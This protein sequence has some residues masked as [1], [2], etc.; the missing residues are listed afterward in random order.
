MLKKYIP[1][2]LGIVI[3]FGLFIISINNYLLF[4]SIAEVF[5]IIVAYGIF[6][7]S[8]NCRQN[9]ENKY[10]LLLGIAYFFVGC[11][12]FLHTLAYKGM[13]VFATDESNLPT[14]LWITAR[15]LE[16]ISLFIAPFFLKRKLNISYVFLCYC[17]L[18][19]IVL[20][21]I[22]Y[23]H[24]F[25]DSFIEGT[26]LTLFKKL[27]ELVI[28]LIFCGA[29]LQLSRNRQRFDSQVLRILIASILI[30]ICAEVAFIFYVD[31]YGLSNFFGHI[32]KIISF[33]LIYNAL[34]KTALIRPFDLLYRDLKISENTLRESEKRL[35]ELN[36]TKDRFFSIIAH[37]LRSPLVSMISVIRYLIDEY[38]SISDSERMKFIKEIDLISN[39]TINLLDNLLDWAKCQTGDM[40]FQPDKYRV[41]DLL[42][43]ATI[44][45]ESYARNKNIVFRIEAENNLCVFVDR[46]MIITVVRNLVSNAIKFSYPNSDIL[47]E[48]NKVKNMAEFK[49]KDT[50]TGIESENI[51]KLFKIEEHF[52]RLGTKKEKGTGLGL[53]LCKNLVNTNS[54]EIWLESNIN[55]GATFY[56]SV[57]LE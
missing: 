17:I 14:Q 11:L 5:S 48:V 16:S 50:G 39:R 40:I 38:K 13:G 31:V 28:S 19:S 29:I 3:L 15:Y 35:Q 52:M 46:N 36:A 55:E 45:L 24:I 27:S 7:I 8:W 34:V 22:F 49:I 21:T 25:P 12:D 4:H 53:I 26:G 30:S 47:I 42:L 20:S 56:F 44:P 6:I 32:L 1:I 37:D 41:H 54:G 2:S 10:L 18:V 33:Y 9:L 51:E 43:E 23:W 57:P